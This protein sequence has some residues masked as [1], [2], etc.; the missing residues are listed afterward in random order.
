M[1]YMA[2]LLSNT[3]IIFSLYDMTKRAPGSQLPVAQVGIDQSCTTS[4]LCLISRAAF[5][6]FM[7]QL[8][9]FD[10]SLSLDYVLAAHSKSQVPPHLFETPFFFQ[11]KGWQPMTS[12][13]FCDA[14]VLEHSRAHLFVYC[15][16]LLC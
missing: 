13:H 15:L 2:T 14:V 11:V 8:W 1:A 3:K 6:S 4:P 10:N 9:K 5:S 16:W 7:E 12:C